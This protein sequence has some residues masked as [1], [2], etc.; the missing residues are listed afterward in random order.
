LRISIGIPKATK[1]CSR[2]VDWAPKIGSPTTQ[3][4]DELPAHQH[5]ERI[6]PKR[7]LDRKFIPIQQA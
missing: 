6:E 2:E 3:T 5:Q 1:L 7:D 4:V